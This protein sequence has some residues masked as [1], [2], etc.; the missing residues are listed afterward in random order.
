MQ[1]LHSITTTWIFLA[2]S[3]CASSSKII[4]AHDDASSTITQRDNNHDTIIQR[5]N[6]NNMRGR[7]RSQKQTLEKNNVATTPNSP[8]LR[9]GKKRNQPSLPRNK[10]QDQEQP[11]RQQQERR[12]ARRTNDFT[13]TPPETLG[14]C[15]APNP[16]SIVHECT[17]LGELCPHGNPGEH[18]CLDTCHRRY[19]TAKH[20][21]WRD[22]ARPPILMQAMAVDSQEELESEP[23]VEL[24]L[25]LYGET[26]KEEEKAAMMIMT[27]TPPPSREPT[28]LPTAPP[29]NESMVSLAEVAN[30]DEDDDDTLG[31]TIGL[32][33]MMD[34]NID[35][36]ENGDDNND[37][38]GD[39]D[40]LEGVIGL[41]ITMDINKDAMRNT[42]GV[43]DKDDDGFYLQLMLDDRISLDDDDNII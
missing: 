42:N 7:L 27:R 40:I 19:C 4:Q 20:G 32:G 41:G 3:S 1:L 11:T 28:K 22:G 16:R 35:P 43:K 33:T 2:S 39:D 12:N 37:D 6:G 31:G 24:D 38:D 9:H 26:E 14:I 5:Q 15:T 13:C 21:T 29:T 8:L 23:V 34:V 30:E 36:N 25:T 17:H 10:D 18:C